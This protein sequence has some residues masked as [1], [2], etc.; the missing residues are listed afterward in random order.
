[1]STGD[2][3]SVVITSALEGEG[4]T[5]TAMN[6]AISCAGLEGTRVL[7]VDADLRKRGLGK[8][9]EYPSS[10]GLVNVLGR[11]AQPESAIL[12][13]NLENLYLLPAGI[14]DGPPTELFAGTRWKEFV[15]WAKGIF[16]IVIV[17]SPPLAAVADS[18][19]IA[20]GCDGILMVVRALSTRRETLQK[21]V[22]HLDRRKLVGAVLNSARIENSGSYY[23]QG[24]K[25]G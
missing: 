22:Q 21:V 3:R 6:L 8:F 17:D 13:T 4:K 2:L 16:R 11:G 23:A 25:V 12:S 5:L 24:P 15:N 10:T 19:L 9:Q 7:L 18:E 1:M 20:A 14:P